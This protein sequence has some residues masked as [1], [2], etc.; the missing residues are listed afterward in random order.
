MPESEDVQIDARER[1]SALEKA[2]QRLVTRLKET[3]RRATSAEERREEV[4]GLLRD[5]TEGT[6]DP[7]AMAE[8]LEELEA[9]NADLRGRMDQGLEGVERL[10]SRVRFMEDQR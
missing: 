4:E 9:E 5:M 6:A 2:V 1:M 7:A 8:R 3:E 10:L